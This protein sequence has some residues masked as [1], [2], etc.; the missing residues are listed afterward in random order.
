MDVFDE[1]PSTLGKLLV[2][3]LVAALFMTGYAVG[4]WTAP[5][6]ACPAG[7]ICGPP[8]ENDPFCPQDGDSIT[9]T[10]DRRVKK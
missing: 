5:K 3:C 4:Y 10:V 1:E 2:Y 9:F 7:F 8:S 6:D